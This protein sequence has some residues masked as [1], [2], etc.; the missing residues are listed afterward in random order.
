MIRALLTFAVMITIES[1]FSAAWGQ[2]LDR[3][4]G[5]TDLA[6]ATRALKLGDGA[7][8]HALSADW[9]GVPTLFVDYETNGGDPDR[10][11]RPLV[12]IQPQPSS[13]Y[14]A[15]EVTLGEQE[16]GVPAII[17][18]G[19]ARATREP[20]KDLIVILA[21][22]QMHYD[23]E[24]TLYE[25]RLFASPKPGE[26]ALQPLKVSGRFDSGCD[27]S[28]RTGASKRYRYKTIAAVQAE[29]KRLGY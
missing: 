20:A 9:N 24:G 8:P 21:W 25:V 26:A 23:V 1:A 16:G 7:A 15:V 22:P 18:L 27:C 17:A 28:W 19:F 10:A 29:L 6:F 4:P 14:R 13:G 2:A 11:E 5:E 3:R 12:A